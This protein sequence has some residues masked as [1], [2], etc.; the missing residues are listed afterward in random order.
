[1]DH[2]E[3]KFHQDRQKKEKE[4]SA[5]GFLSQIKDLMD[6]AKTQLKEDEEVV[7]FTTPETV[8]ALP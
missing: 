5:R 8:L 2:L 7:G 1:M 4:H 6:A 3:Q